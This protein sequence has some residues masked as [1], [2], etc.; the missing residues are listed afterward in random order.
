MLKTLLL[1]WL[2]LV[3]L[4]AVLGA[5]TASFNPRDDQFVV[6]GLMRA[7]AEFD[8]AGRDVARSRIL[9]K[10]G[11]LS[12]SEIEVKEA[13][14]ARV[15]VDYLQQA[16]TA[17]AAMTH[18]SVER[19]V[20]VRDGV[21]LGSV[22]VTLRN[23]GSPEA[24]LAGLG[25]QLDPDIRAQ[26]MPG[27]VRNVYV[28]LKTEAGAP[29]AAISLP[30]EQHLP[31]LRRGE[32]STLTFRLLKDL[33]NVVAA[34]TYGGKTDERRVVLES[35]LHDH[36]VAMQSSQFSQEGDLGAE[37][38]YDLHLSEFSPDHRRAYR[39]SAVGLPREI[40]V[41]FRD[42]SSKA[43]LTQVL[44]APAETEKALQVVV[45]LPSRES[46]ALRVDKPL[47]FVVAVLEVGAPESTAPSA[48]AKRG[49]TRLELLPRGVPRVDI[50][51]LNLFQEIRPAD[52]AHVRLTVANVGSRRVDG[53][54]L[55]VDA[56]SEWVVD[57]NPRVIP[58]L[59]QGESRQVE[60][61][62]TPPADVAVGD[63]E[64]RVRVET[65]NEATPA[66]TE[67]KLIRVRV[68]ASTKWGLWITL[69]L[70]IA[71][72]MGLLMRVTLQ[73]TRR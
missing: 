43:R 52:S 3:P 12:P 25:A 5:Q 49:E 64:T 32:A 17:V 37:V 59:E 57:L 38:V 39:L 60:I 47:S 51:A 48:N 35:D 14:F 58:A 13:E 28:S 53:I 1:S 41:E 8:R 62:I 73:Q 40:P 26:L 15:R 72:A 9:A 10:R 33:D 24:E 42:S 63:Y 7:K 65:N 6:L 23:S 46:D 30:Y 34:V 2:T 55:H 67:D 16:M 21:G 66:S 11:F 56:P 68:S 44:F 36:A 45:R 20:R 27:L 4:G 71:G 54:R 29:G 50:R 22:R 18:I 19:V 69:G 31:E 61:A 70:A